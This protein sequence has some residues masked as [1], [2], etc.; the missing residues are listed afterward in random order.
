[1]EVMVAGDHVVVEAFTELAP[2]YEHTMDQELQRYWGLGYAAFIEQFVE[3]AAIQDGQVVLDVATGT[4]SIPLH[5]VGTAH[6][7]RVV[8]LDITLAMLDQ[9]R[10]R[11]EKNGASACIR[12]VCASATAIPFAGECFDVT[13]CGL[14]THHI[15]VAQLLTEVQRVLKPG[16]RL[17]VSDVGASRFWRSFWGKVL[18][19][20]LL[21]RY[22][23]KKNPRIE[24]ELDAFSNVL[25]AGE[26]KT[27]LLANGFSEIRIVESRARRPWYPNRLTISALVGNSYPR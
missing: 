9:G 23:L 4:A 16:G 8:G 14:G 22:G 7:C 27:L 20:I 15:G 1:V 3:M 26:W 11:V 18:L 24:A 17:L 6:S 13:L 25:T 2:R 5:V 12:L 19:R 10:K 21:F